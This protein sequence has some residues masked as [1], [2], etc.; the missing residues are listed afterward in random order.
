MALKKC[1]T[2]DGGVAA[3][4]VLHNIKQWEIPDLIE[5]LSCIKTGPLLYEYTGYILQNE[6]NFDLETLIIEAY[7]IGKFDEL[8][9]YV[10]P[11]IAF[12]NKFQ[13]KNLLILLDI[14]EQYKG[15]HDYYRFLSNYCHHII[16]SN[17]YSIVSEIINYI[18]NETLYWVLKEIGASW[19]E[20]DVLQADNFCEQCIVNDNVI[21]KKLS[22]YYFALSIQYSA[23]L[24]N[25]YLSELNDMY[26]CNLELRKNIVSLFVSY[27]ISKCD[28]SASE[29]QSKIVYNKLSSIPKDI[30]YIKSEFI[31]QISC[32]NK[33]PQ[34]LTKI[35]KDIISEPCVDM[36]LLNKLDNYLY[37]RIQN[38]KWENIL[39]DLF[40]IFKVNDYKANYLDF[41]SKMSSVISEL[42]KYSIPI[43]KLSINYMISPDIQKVFF[44]IG[45]F[46]NVGNLHKYINDSE[47]EKEYLTGEQLVRVIKGILYY[48]VDSKLI[49]KT[50]FYLLELIKDSA[51]KFIEFCIDEVFENYSATMY[52]FS[53]MYLSSQ[54]AKQSQL[55][56]QIID[57]YENRLNEQSCVRAIRDLTPSYERIRIYNNAQHV[58][59][60]EMLKT[61]DKYSLTAQLFT[62]QR[63]KYGSKVGYFIHQSNNQ[64][65]LQESVYQHISHEIELPIQLAID[66]IEYYDKRI[67]FLKEVKEI[68]FDN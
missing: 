47:V 49:C 1:V 34:S 31:S 46:V 14:L 45:L 60:N 51:N 22:I 19:Y 50:S 57:I 18:N 64:T 24:F 44:G 2:I 53:K 54:N 25:K 29:A 5:Q 55:A 26:E 3:Y 16:N 63:L 10:S 11:N 40:M 12:Q 65:K 30:S 41:F 38:D 6:Y 7:R 56:T 52:K 13:S 32:Y 48:A 20:K 68:A 36:E 9:K 67:M 28:D 59:S 15:S 27:L 62:R 66:P 42:E 58:K 37:D 39:C 35:F 23:D 21:S 43:T 4:V 61:A 17:A 33:L 8:V